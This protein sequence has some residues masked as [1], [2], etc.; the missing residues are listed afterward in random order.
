MFVQILVNKFPKL[1]RLLVQYGKLSVWLISTFSTVC[2][3]DWSMSWFSAVGCQWAIKAVL[4]FRVD[5]IFMDSLWTRLCE[6]ISYT[7]LLKK[8]DAESIKK[9]LCNDFFICSVY[10]CCLLSLFYPCLVKCLWLSSIE[11]LYCCSVFY[12]LLCLIKDLVLFTC[13]YQSK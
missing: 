8:L 13:F 7:H 1:K 12:I 11:S 2:T 9:S 4:K 5:S 3:P 6:M 10:L